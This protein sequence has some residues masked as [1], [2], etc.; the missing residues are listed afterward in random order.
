MASTFP[1]RE[2]ESPDLLN[3]VL[4]RAY[5]VNWEAVAYAVILVLAI[6]TRFV[7]LGARVVSHDESLHTYYSWRL[8]TAGDFQHTPLM[9]GPILFHVTAL[10]YA[11]FGDNDFS[12]R[13]YPAALGVIMVMMPLL[14]RRWLGRWGAL[15]A[16]VGLLLSPLLMYYNRYIREDTPS[17]VS[18][19]F[20]AYAI[21]M[22][23]DGPE[24]LRRRARWLYLLIGSMLWSLGTKEV[25][26]FYIAIFGSILTLY[27]LVRVYQAWKRTPTRRAYNLI[28]VASLVGALMA[29]ALYMVF[30]ISLSNYATL[31]LRLT[32][33]S[34]QISLIFS[35]GALGQDFQ[36]FASWALIVIGV[37]LALVLGTALWATRRGGLRVRRSDVLILLLIAFVVSLALI[38][39]EELTQEPKPVEAEG[40]D[41]IVVPDIS[42]LPIVATWVVV[43]PVIGF[44]F[45]ARALGWWRRLYRFAEFDILIVMGSFT[46]PWLTAVIL[47]ATGADPTDYSSLG[48]QRT[49]LCLAPLMALSIISGLLWNWKRWIICALVFY[50]PFAFFFTTMFTNPNG[51]ATGMIGSL[52]YWLKQQ[53]V[54]RGSQPRYYYALIVMPIYEYLPIIGSVLAMLAG[55]VKFWRYQAHKDEPVELP[56]G[57]SLGIA[58]ADVALS[59]QQARDAT[60]LLQREGALRR[61]GFLIFV[62]WWGI[63]NFIGYTLAGEKMPWLGTHLTVPFIF[64]TAW[65][66]GVVFSRVDWSLFRWRGWLYLILLPLFGITLFQA[67]APFL[68]GQSP[69]VALQGLQQ[70]QLSD[71][72]RWLAIVGV[73]AVVLYLIVRLG[74]LTGFLQLRRMIG[75]AAFLTLSLMT[76]RTAVTASFVNYDY[77]NEFLVYAHG[78]PGIKLMMEQIEDISRRTTDGMNVKFAWG[79]NAW[80]VTWYFRDLT[81][82]TFFGE[83]PTA[84]ALNDAVV[85]YASNDIRSRVEPLLEDR[86]IRFEYIRMWWPDQ[87]YFY[88]T[89]QRVINTFDFSPENTNAAL[90]RRGM[91]DI[92][93]NRDYTRYGQAISKDYSLQNWP[94]S[95]RFFFYVRKDVA[96][97][98]WN[99]GTGEGTVL[100]PLE[101]QPVNICTANW[102]QRQADVIFAAG[103]DL[104]MNHPLDIAV[105]NENDRVYVAEEFNN[106]ISI[107]NREGQFISALQ[108]GTENFPE[109]FNRPNGVSVAP[110]TDLYVADTWNFR[111]REFSPDGVPG[112]SWGTPGQFGAEAPVEPVDGFWGPRDVEVDGEGRVYVSDTGN[113][114]I[115]VYDA[116]GNYLLDI[117][118]AGSELGNLDEP[119]GLAIDSANGLL[120][121]ADTWNQRVSVF[122]L[123]GTPQYSF[124]VRGWYDDLGNRPY[125]ALDTARNLLYVTDPDAGRVLVYNGQG[126]CI[127][128]F[129]QPSDA[130]VDGSQFNIIG[131]IAVD[132]E[133][134]VYVADSG[135]ARVLRFAP[136]VDTILPPG[137]PN[138]VE[139]TE[140]LGASDAQVTQELQPL[141]SST[142]EVTSEATE[143]VVG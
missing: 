8:E 107:F 118:S 38:G 78:A 30:S 2:N 96:A 85:V 5:T 50:V 3:R 82:A 103:Q 99:L 56:S 141:G 65:Y 60:P 81:N 52:G 35:G 140:Q 135:A 122:S 61:P 124:D 87:E 113:K 83:N 20:M 89:A 45:L 46:L 28:A 62:S 33:L 132:Q 93:W 55:M 70:G 127:G 42:Y 142:D 108:G 71:F 133:G 106:R 14:F 9:H 105:D 100:N 129:G 67:V 66:F 98:V 40:A 39:F 19:M 111:I 114:R 41:T 53:A 51:L 31:D 37:I 101:N 17:F 95:E 12:A 123:D 138:D 44:L 49:L 29:L 6:L 15:L 117:G 115:R 11:L 104:V 77:A 131:G 13:I 79:G 22:Y 72:Y 23:L 134:Y 137:Q 32:Y 43:L 88:L 16:A 69:F 24:H 120:Y 36:A 1:N 136:F 90:I 94:V 57:E 47:R 63:F 73:A 4:A 64:L 59:Q 86:Y 21:F 48:I 119:S 75:V 27:W 139:A 80:P 7:D 126:D 143:D 18:A 102:Q 74:L 125:L 84:Q 130:P 10:M 26:F 112:V 116:D 109:G 121:V 91:F 68:G 34:Q 128:S 54:Q 97:Q 92:W 25:A 58:D 76:Y 110:N